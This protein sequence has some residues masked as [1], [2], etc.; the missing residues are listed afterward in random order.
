M[1]YIIRS[2]KVKGEGLYLCMG[3]EQALDHFNG[4]DSPRVRTY[5][6]LENAQRELPHAE[7]IF[8]GPCRIVRLLSHEEAKRKFAAGVL[9]EMAAFMEMWAKHG[10]VHTHESADALRNEA[11]KLWPAK[12]ER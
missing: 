5:G 9:R 4:P 3:E 11:S 2:G 7:N 6:L 12:G 10:H 8:R 1:K